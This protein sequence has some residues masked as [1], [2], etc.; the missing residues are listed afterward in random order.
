[1][2]MEDHPLLGSI[3]APWPG[4]RMV[5]LLPA[6][7]LCDYAWKTASGFGVP[8]YREKS[9]K[10]R[11]CLNGIPECFFMTSSQGRNLFLFG[12]MKRRLQKDLISVFSHK[13]RQLHSS[14]E[15]H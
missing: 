10:I 6:W 14:L 4:Q 7:E 13:K 12:L 9:K 15:V 11:K 2:M 8:Q 1:M 5:L 3:I